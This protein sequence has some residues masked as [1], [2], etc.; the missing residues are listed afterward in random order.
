MDNPAIFKAERAD[1]YDG[2]IKDWV[3][4]YAYLLQLLPKLLGKAPDA[5]SNQLLVVGF[6]TGNEIKAMVD[7]KLAWKITGVDPS[8]DMV[9]QAREKLSAYPN[10]RLLDGR[11]GDLEPGEKF[12]AATLILV[13]HFIPDDG[14]KLDLLQHLAKRLKPGAPLILMD[15]FGT[16]QEMKHNLAILRSMLPPDLDIPTVN[17][18]LQNLPQRI[19]FISENRLIDLMLEAGFLAPVR[20]FQMAIYGAWMARK[21]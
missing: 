21:K 11:V 5:H 6:G 4:Q 19:Q 1:G 15:I 8:P 13:L 7:A 18:R 10:I 16:S 20:F 17:N 3:P 9:R 12:D 2:F 14:A